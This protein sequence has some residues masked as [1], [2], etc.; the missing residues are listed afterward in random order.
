MEGFTEDAFEQVLA[1]VKK[2]PIGRACFSHFPRLLDGCRPTRVA[3]HQTHR[4]DRL[5]ETLG[6]MPSITAALIGI[7]PDRQA[8]I[9]SKAVLR[10][11]QISEL[12]VCILWDRG[13]EHNIQELISIINT[14]PSLRS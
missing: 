14:H 4:F 6:S 11:R 13:H 7:C 3:S 9:Q 5:C 8:L 10:L 1:A 2:T 12:R